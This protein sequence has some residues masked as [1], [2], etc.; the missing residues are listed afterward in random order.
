LLVQSLYCGFY[1]DVTVKTTYCSSNLL[2][3][4]YLNGQFFLHL[5]S[6]FAK[7][8]FMFN[9]LSKTKYAHIFLILILYN[10]SKHSRYKNQYEITV[11]RELPLIVEN[12]D[13]AAPIA[14]WMCHNP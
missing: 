14:S 4:L 10:F 5:W 2:P 9:S 6:G 8:W 3:S 7:F 12:V 13:L 11:F 1:I